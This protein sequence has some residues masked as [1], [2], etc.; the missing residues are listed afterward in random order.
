MP[1]SPL[2]TFEYGLWHAL[3]RTKLSTAEQ[4]ALGNEILKLAKDFLPIITTGTGHALRRQGLVVGAAVHYVKNDDDARSR[5]GRFDA[6][7]I[8]SDRK[9][10]DPTQVTCQ[11]C[12][13]RMASPEYAVESV[14]NISV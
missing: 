6:D 7:R 10:S 4:T 5:C 9:T 11:H 12:H 3:R 14:I 2:A 8:P 1:K 13:K